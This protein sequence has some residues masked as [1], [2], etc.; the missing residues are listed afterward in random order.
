MYGIQNNSV[1]IFQLKKSVASLKQGDHSFVQHLGSMKSMWN[2]LDMYRP[3]TT[4]SAVLLKKADEDKVFQLLAS[5]G[6]E[7]EDLRSHLLMT[8]ELPSFTNVCHAVKREETRQSVMN[9]EPKSNSEARVFKTNHKVTGDRVLGKKADWK[10][11]YCNIKGHL[12][13]KCWILH[14]ELKPKFDREG[15]MIKDG[16]GRVTPK[17]FQSACFSTDGMANFS[18]N[19]A[20]LINEFAV[21]LQKKQGSTEPDEMT[22]K[23]PTIMLGKFA[24]FLADSKNT[25]KGNIPSIISAISTALNAN[26]THDFWII[27]SGATDHITNKPSNLHDFQRTIDPIHVYV[28][29]GKGE[30]IL[31]KERLDC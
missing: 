26:V 13:E 28:A 12:R 22:P 18:T 23:N 3:Q 27:D 20:S 11:S 31:G 15:R 8:Q 30:P 14:P 21:F 16:K 24:G 6:A 9:V 29:N 5:L 1:R 7:Y 17:A 2:E 4:D 10:C 19:H 25:S